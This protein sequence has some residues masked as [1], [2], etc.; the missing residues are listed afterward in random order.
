[1]S[2]N[3]WKPRRARAAAAVL[4]TWA[5]WAAAP[6]GAGAQPTTQ[7]AAPLKLTDYIPLPHPTLSYAL[8]LRHNSFSWRLPTDADAE[9]VRLQRSAAAAKQG[10][11]WSEALTAY[12]RL[13]TLLDHF[14]EDPKGLEAARNGVIHAAD[15]ILAANPNDA[16]AALQKA[17]VLIFM[18]RCQESIAVTDTLLAAR[19]TL[20]E[21]YPSAMRARARRVLDPDLWRRLAKF[22]NV[23]AGRQELRKLLLPV[24]IWR[25][26]AE[27]KLPRTAHWAF[28][29]FSVGANS[30]SAVA[31]SAGIVFRE[32]S[33]RDD[34]YFARAL[35]NQVLDTPGQ[36]ELLDKALQAGRKG[37][38]LRAHLTVLRLLGDIYR[39]AARASAELQVSVDN[40]L[41]LFLILYR[42]APRAQMARHL[43]GVEAL[44]REAPGAFWEL[45]LIEGGVRL[46]MGQWSESRPVFERAAKRAPLAKQPVQGLVLGAM[47]QSQHELR[48]AREA[49][50][51]AA[52]RVEELRRIHADA[53]TAE[54]LA[55]LKDAQGK[56][57]D[58]ETRRDRAEAVHNPPL[59]NP[60]LLAVAPAAVG[61]L[62]RRLHERPDDDIALW[63]AFLLD[64][65]GRHE[66]ASR[67]YAKLATVDKKPEEV[68]F[69]ARYGQLA[70][71]I[72]LA[73]A[74]TQDD[75]KA[76]YG[77]IDALPRTQDAVT[78]G[79]LLGT[80]AV[81]RLLTG[82]QPGGRTTLQDAL[83]YV[84]PTGQ[85]ERLA[86]R[87]GVQRRRLAGET[88]LVLNTVGPD[89]AGVLKVL[90]AAGLTAAQAA[91][92]VARAPCTAL[93]N[94]TR[95]R[96]Q[97]LKQKLEAAGAT[98]VLY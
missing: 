5:A 53:P 50:G 65:L 84:D 33:R 74:A 2:R 85:V 10:G 31:R 42:K 92:R 70:E 67:A 60:H 27:R 47:L 39:T 97:E 64:R 58:A 89:K 14:R 94:L 13:A 41:T 77:M 11:R 57:A 80:A 21:A 23:R 69:I 76:V 75:L 28:Y 32:S 72:K 17:D 16:T 91:D 8:G 52:E 4:A 68:G 20:W 71:R 44:E 88:N 18:K 12:R 40:P 45:P 1:M 66:E 38:Q 78:Q 36:I 86:R 48:T 26:R 81:L 34:V 96:A 46:A 3:A 29:Q 56:L 43:A 59:T 90:E 55:K 98:V 87:L 37:F 73:G 95:H 7:P 9:I 24:L 54:N 30:L 82:D 93:K 51:R 63:A 49:A 35:A 61:M 19:P 15:Q 62:Q 83:E 25:A 22:E 6:G 79:M